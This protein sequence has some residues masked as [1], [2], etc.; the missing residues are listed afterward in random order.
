MPLIRESNLSVAWAKAFLALMRRGVNG[1]SPLFI[2]ITGMQDGVPVEVASIRLLLDQEFVRLGLYECHTVANTI[3]PSNLW[4][5]AT[6]RHDLYARY[7]RILPRLLRR[8]ENR[9]GLYFERMIAFGGDRPADGN[10]IE[11]LIRIWGEGVRRPT[12]FV[13]NVFDP[14]RDHTRQRRRGFPCLHHVTFTPLGRGGLAV[15]ASYPIQFLFE[16]GYGNYLGLY[17]LGQFVAHEVNRELTQFTCTISTARLGSVAKNQLQ[18]FAA[19]LRE[20]LQGQAHPAQ[21]G[22]GAG[23]D[24]DNAG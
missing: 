9:N 16:K 18:V 5:R 22:A 19:D 8:P 15:N 24:D 11:H 20:L 1:I 10:Q 23:G 13:A 17:Q 3:F 14:A 4:E 7:R 2:E 21:Q 12:A 6:D